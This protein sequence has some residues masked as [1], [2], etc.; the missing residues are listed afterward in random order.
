MLELHQ[1]CSFQQ[2][3]DDLIVN[4]IA[5]LSWSDVSELFGKLLATDHQDIR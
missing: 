4:G 5:H 3:V 2:N 1:P